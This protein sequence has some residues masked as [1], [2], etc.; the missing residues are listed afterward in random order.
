MSEVVASVPKAIG[1]SCAWPRTLEAANKLEARMSPVV[2]LVK[3]A[4]FMGPNVRSVPYADGGAD[5][6]LRHRPAKGQSPF[7]SK[8]YR[9]RFNGFRTNPN[10]SSRRCVSP[11]GA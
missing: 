5:L 10:P 4:A 2:D 1:A 3:M 7:L 6:E 8:R 11:S 9:I